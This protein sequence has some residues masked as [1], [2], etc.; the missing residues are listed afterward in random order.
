MTALFADVVG[1]TVLGER[2]DP[3]DF[4]DV[5]G[6]AV[7][8]MAG[9]VERFGGSVSE[10]SGDGLLA[11]F[12]APVAHEDDPERAMLAGLGSRSRWPNTRSG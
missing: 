4:T 2:L 5:V 3:E 11:L 10:L 8:E 1:S 6:G 7:R 12:G 9:C